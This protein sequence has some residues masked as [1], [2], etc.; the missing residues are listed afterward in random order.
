[1]TQRQARAIKLLSE[2]VRKPLGKIM[3]EAGY[4]LATSKKPKRLTNS[5]AFIFFMEEKLPIEKLLKVHREALYATK[6]NDIIRKWLPDYSIRFRALHDAYIIKGI[7][8]RRSKNDTHVTISL[9]SRP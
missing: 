9:D 4:S 3:L 2:N 7:L 8:P 1:M 5:K 6:W